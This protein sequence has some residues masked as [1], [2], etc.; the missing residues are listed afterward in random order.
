VDEEQLRALIRLLKE[1]GL[2]EITVCEGDER[3][4]VCQAPSGL[5][6]TAAEATPAAASA[7]VPDDGSFALVAPLVGTFYSRP[8]PEDEPFVS[9]GSIVAV[10]DVVGIIEAMKVMNE[11]RAEEP[12]RVRQVQAVDGQAVEYGQELVLFE[13]L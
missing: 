1:E 4:T 8:S 12:G 5:V 13:R 11:V 10:G 6:S 7:S 3:I 2:T 9:P